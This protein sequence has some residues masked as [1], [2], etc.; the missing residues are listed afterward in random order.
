MSSVGHPL[1]G[2]TVYGGGRTK[3]E[4]LNANTVMGQCLHAK[5]IGFVH[6]TSGERMFFDSDL[7]EYF[8][9]ILDKLEKI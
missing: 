3:I 2:D 4:T 7:P 6:P 5:T 9:K 8:N 1:F